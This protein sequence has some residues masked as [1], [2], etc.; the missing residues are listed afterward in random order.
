MAPTP[1]HPFPLPRAVRPIVIIGAGGIVREAHLP[2]YRLA[3][4]P[5]V[6]LV[7]LDRGKAEALARQF[8]VPRVHAD[9]A[10]AVRAAPPEA[11]FD[12]AVPASAHAAVLAALP[13]GAPV[14]LQKPFGEN[15]E[16][17]R[18]LRELCRRRE[19]RAAVNFQLRV[20]PCVREARRLVEDGAIGPV[21]D[22]EVRVTVD[23]P[24]QLWAFL[25]QS[26]RVEILYHSI[27]Y[28]DLIRSFFGEPR[29]VQARTLRHPGSPRL[30]ATRSAILLDYGDLRRATITANHGHAFGPRH[31]ES[32]I[33]WEGEGG[34]IVA[35]LGALLNYPHGEADTLEACLPGQPGGPPEW[36]PLPLAGNWFPHA[37][38]ATMAALMRYAN[39][40]SDRLPSGVDDAFQTMAVVEAAYA[41]AGAPSTPIPP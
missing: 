37:F 25:E 22:L 30:A 23:T 29:G 34:A 32:Y 31:Q 2:A 27:H 11:V 28:I 26:P 12:V 17:A 13:A 38:I 15:L 33:K 20:A 6:A 19:L 7:D 39:G 40:E 41:S 4:F 8:A 35:R 24:W 16:Q 9:L 21:H 5:V 10:E 14:L 3:N 36:R 1:G 18:A